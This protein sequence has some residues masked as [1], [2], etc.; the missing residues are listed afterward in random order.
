MII[1]HID[2]PYGFN[3]GSREPI[4]ARFILSK[5]DMAKVGDATQGDEFALPR[6][7]E[8]YFV[9]CED[10]GQIYEFHKDAATPNGCVFTKL[11]RKVDNKTI[12]ES[13]DLEAYVPIDNKTI[14]LSE[15]VL[16]AV[17]E[18]LLDGVATKA[19]NLANGTAKVNVL[20]D[21]A[22]IKLVD[23]LNQLAVEV[24]EKTIKVGSEGLF[25]DFDLLP[26]NA[27]IKFN[28][29]GKLEAQYKA[30]EEKGL[31][32]DGVE[33]EV[34]VDDDKVKFDSE[35]KLTATFLR[36]VGSEGIKVDGNKITAVVDDATIK[37]VN[38]KLEV[39]AKEAVGK[40]ADGLYVKYD[41]HTVV[42]SDAEE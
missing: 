6:W 32:L 41:G 36:Y 29:E 42:I 34:K 39:Q 18:Q 20:F 16:K 19:E 27:T 24:D 38:D 22:T 11:T 9:L 3:V 30:D 5:A 1:N 33:F 17:P 35:G 7:P 13:A 31:H 40:D 12:L 10:D 23:A 28:S 14:I 26:D 8:H 37:V 25:A 21:P 15:G 2:L 4:D